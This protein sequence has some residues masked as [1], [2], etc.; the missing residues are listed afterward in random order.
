MKKA[1]VQFS[2]RMVVL[3]TVAVTV[4]VAVSVLGM[5]YDSAYTE[6]PKVLDHYLG[7]ASVVFVAYSG[8][9]ALE[10]WLVKRAA[11]HDTTQDTTASATANTP[12]DAG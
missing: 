9:S 5:I 10:K 1:Y 11:I 7:Y 6:L 8:N 3:V 12:P 2:K 4:I